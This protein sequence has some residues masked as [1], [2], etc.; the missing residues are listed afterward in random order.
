MFNGSTYNPAKNNNQC[1]I[2]KI[3]GENYLKVFPFDKILTQ[4]FQHIGVGHSQAQ[5]GDQQHKLHDGTETKRITTSIIQVMNK[6][7]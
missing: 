6:L 5:K 3:Y 1:F 2:N 7:N 4:G